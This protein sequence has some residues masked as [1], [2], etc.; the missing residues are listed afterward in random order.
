M[1]CQDYITE[2]D[3][4]YSERNEAQSSISKTQ[5]T[6]FPI[7]RIFRLFVRAFDA[8]QCLITGRS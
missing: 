7:I 1:D 2:R 5:A 8:L 6:A 4:T 3:S